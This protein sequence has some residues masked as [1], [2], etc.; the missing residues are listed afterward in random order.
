MPDHAHRNGLNG[1]SGEA[2]GDVGQAG[3]PRF[4]VHRHSRHGVDQRD[5]IGTGCLCGKR[6][7]GNIGDVRRQFDNQ[8]QFGFSSYLSGYIGG[9]IRIGA[10]SDPPFLHI[11]AGDVDFNAG[12][13]GDRI[14]HRGNT[15]IFVYRFAKNVRNDGDA[16]L[17]QKGHLFLNKRADADVLQS[18]GIE[19]AAGGFDDAGR[20]ISRPRFERE[21]L[22]HNGTQSA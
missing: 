22:D 16:Q 3:A 9:H 20:R 15:A 21:A 6:D 13:S 11:R 4:Y 1:R 7:L 19:H 12:D 2:A 5:R 10:E 14:E 17:P 8:G 18:D